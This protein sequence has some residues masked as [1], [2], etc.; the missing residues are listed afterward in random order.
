MLP[1]VDPR[2]RLAVDASVAWYDDVFALHG[3]EVHTADGLWWSP[4]DPPPWHSSAKTLQP[5]V[6][7]DAV[8]DALTTR[9]HGSV[10]DS[11]CDLALDA[12]GFELLFAATWL[13][14]SPGRRPSVVPPEWSVVA[15]PH[16]L[17]DWNKAHDYA[18]VLPDEVLTHPRF[19]VLAQHRDGQ[20]VAGA[21][22]HDADPATGLSNVWSGEGAAIDWPAIV[23]V[24]SAASP[25][26]PVVAY[27]W[28]EAL[29]GA[30]TAGFTAVGAQRVWER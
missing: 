17:A 23:D 22:T 18:G 4:D 9:K 28:G 21:I 15:T 3:L 5:G 7:N 13:Y 27:E 2:L 25:D 29:E 30:L 19:Q 11:F 14:L 26:R 8:V 12:Y 6:S 24:V 16:L 1:T 20:L 10:A